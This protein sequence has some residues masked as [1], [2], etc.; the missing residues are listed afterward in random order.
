MFDPSE[1]AEPDWHL[2]IEQDV[3]GECEKYGRVLHIAVDAESQGYVYMKFEAIGA[4]QVALTSLNGRYF[5]GKQIE[6]SFIPEG[7]YNTRYPRV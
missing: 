4:A 2:E 5:A 7:V 6:G 1:E 3:K